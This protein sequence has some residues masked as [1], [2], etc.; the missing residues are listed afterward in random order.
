MPQQDSLESFFSN[1]A[2]EL[3]LEGSEN[4]TVVVD[5]AHIPLQFQKKKNAADNTNETF[6][7]SMSALDTVLFPPPFLKDEYYDRWSSN[8]GISIGSDTSLNV[9]SRSREG[10]DAATTNRIT[11]VDQF[12]D[13]IIEEEE[14][15]TRCISTHPSLDSTER[16]LRQLPVMLDNPRSNN[17]R[18]KDKMKKRKPN[19]DAPISPVRTKDEEE[20]LPRLKNC[21]HSDQLESYPSSIG[22]RK[23]SKSVTMSLMELLKAGSAGYTGF[24]A[25]DDGGEDLDIDEDWNGKVM[26]QPKTK[27]VTASRS[28]QENEQHPL[29]CGDDIRSSSTNHTSSQGRKTPTASASPTCISEFPYYT[30]TKRG[31][32]KKSPATM[33]LSP[34]SAPRKG[35]PSN[36]LDNHHGKS[37][38]RNNSS[39]P[40]PSAS[41]PAVVEIG[42]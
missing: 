6:S 35:R 16:M 14:K 19:R 31:N 33:R 18:K 26:L 10:R 4:L 30:T 3:N 8:E 13:S 32:R 29:A 42:N 38:P 27:M 41:L 9:P 23:L 2:L 24:L 39:K 20:D 21:P 17:T 22:M 28:R 15:Q 36:Q 37:T 40:R 12:I 1:L 5:N 34:P 7:S 11:A 25:D